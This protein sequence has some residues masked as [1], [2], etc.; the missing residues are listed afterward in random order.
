MSDRPDLAIHEL[1]EKHRCI[2]L[3]WAI[4]DVQERRPDLTDDQSWTVLKACKRNHDCESGLT[5]EHIDWTAENMFPSPSETEA[6]REE[7]ND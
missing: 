6:R 2:A 3:I 7:A 4:E 1:L 5:W